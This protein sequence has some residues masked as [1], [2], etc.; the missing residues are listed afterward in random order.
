[1]SMS[2]AV[3]PDVVMCRIV[4][5]FLKFKDIAQLDTAVANHSLRRYVHAIFSKMMPVEAIDSSR[6]EWYRAR[7]LSYKILRVTTILDDNFV[8]QNESSFNNVEFCAAAKLSEHALQQLLTSAKDLKIFNARSFYAMRLCKFQYLD[9][10]LP[11][12]EVDVMG[13]EYCKEDTLIALVKHCPLLRVI[14]TKKCDQFSLRLV[15]ALA[16]HCSNLREVYLSIHRNYDDPE[17]QSTG[18]CELFRNSI[19]LRIVDCS[20]QFTV[21]SLQSVSA[22]QRNLTSVTLRGSYFFLQDPALNALAD[23]ALIALAQNN[24]Q[25]NTVKLSYFHRIADGVLLAFTQY[26]PQL[27]TFSLRYCQASMSGLLAMRTSCTKLTQFEV[28]FGEPLVGGSLFNYL[29]LCILT[30]LIIRPTSLTAS[31]FISVA[32]T[33]PTVR[34]LN[35]VP[36]VLSQTSELT[37]NVLCEALSHL[38]NLE[39]FDVAGNERQRGGVQLDDSVLRALA[40]HCPKLTY[41]NV[42]NHDKLGNAAL[43]GLSHLPLLRVLNADGCSY[44][45]DSGLVAIAERCTRLEELSIA[46]CVDITNV[47][48]NTLAR[49]CP[50]LTHVQLYRCAGVQNSSIQNLIRHAPYLQMLGLADNPQLNFTAVAQLPK[51]CPCLRDLHLFPSSGLTTR[52]PYILEFYASYRNNRHYFDTVFGWSEERRINHY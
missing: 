32:L 22:Y 29:Q 38:P 13:N 4:L 33:N 2:I 5:Q 51:F 7:H 39:V 27:H 20:G 15:E 47:G 17:S 23:A 41:A 10:D 26:L 8:F 30:T 46:H 3:L 40:L 52:K 49:C 42:S 19:Q 28:Y 35:I 14:N 43:S 12:L 6:L 11:L 48:I 1:M 50:N 34:T 24:T 45:L 16:M 36:Q 18:Y 44:F 9:V 21:M 31:E 25:I 37:P